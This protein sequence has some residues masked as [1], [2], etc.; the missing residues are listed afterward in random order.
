M[1]LGIAGRV[2]LVPGASAGLGRAVAH[3][4]AAEGARVVVSAR[5]EERLRR[6]AEE[7]AAATGAEVLAVPADMSRA[8]DVEALVAA[9]VARFGT[10]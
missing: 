4:L 1:E 10:V 2:A 7:I 5:G 6:T 8:E 9:A 3:A